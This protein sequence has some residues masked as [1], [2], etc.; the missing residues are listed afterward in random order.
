MPIKSI[1]DPTNPDYEAGG[2]DILTGNLGGTAENMPESLVDGKVE[3]DE[4]DDESTKYVDGAESAGEAVNQI[5]EALD[6][7]RHNEPERPQVTP[8][9]GPG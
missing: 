3:T 9:D 5:A 1:F 7:K 2:M 4:E 8:P 6:E